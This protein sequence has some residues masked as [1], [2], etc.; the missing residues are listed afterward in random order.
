MK[1]KLSQRI[2]PQID[3]FSILK[4]LK[5]EEELK[6]HRK[7]RHPPSKMPHQDQNN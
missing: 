4:M 1:Q 6:S 5:S 2:E 7:R 3:Y